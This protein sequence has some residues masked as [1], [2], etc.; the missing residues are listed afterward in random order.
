MFIDSLP[1]NIVSIDEK[2]LF[3]SFVQ[4]LTDLGIVNL[5]EGKTKLVLD[6]V[7]LR[8]Y[9]HRNRYLNSMKK[10][11]MGLIER[12][13]IL[14]RSPW[15]IPECEYLPLEIYQILSSFVTRCHL[16]HMDRQHHV[17]IAY[18]AVSELL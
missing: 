2:S 10:P 17:S 13:N 6:P 18:K 5:V 9:Y 16:T 7:L 11:L 12:V 15:S 8:K 14:S 4:D 3:L 1:N